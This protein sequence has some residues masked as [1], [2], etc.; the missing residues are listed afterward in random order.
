V[1]PARSIPWELLSGST[2]KKKSLMLKETNV[3][4]KLVPKIKD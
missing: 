1:L 2:T 4:A 3:L